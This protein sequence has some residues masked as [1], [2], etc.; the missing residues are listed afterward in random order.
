MRHF[1]S[2]AVMQ[3]LGGDDQARPSTRLSVPAIL[4]AAIDLERMAVNISSI[5]V[6]FLYLD[7]DRQDCIVSH[8][9]SFRRR[10][11]AWRE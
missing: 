4:E 2:P 8:C 10:W 3:V 7:Q 9:S 5:A 1:L 11:F 6:P